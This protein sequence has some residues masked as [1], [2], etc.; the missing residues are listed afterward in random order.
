MATT[1]QISAPEILP[2]LA[3]GI[4]APLPYLKSEPGQRISNRV[5]TTE[6]ASSR[7]RAPQTRFD[8]CDP[9]CQKC[10]YRGAAR[11]MT[12]VRDRCSVVISNQN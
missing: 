9:A 7:R 12:G 6:N 4:G 11:A 8:L 1:G 5:L 3:P 10:G 2:K